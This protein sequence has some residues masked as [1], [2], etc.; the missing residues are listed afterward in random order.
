MSDPK[1]LSPGTLETTVTYLEMLQRPTRP[2]GA[3]PRADLTVQQAVL[4]TVS[5]Y[6]YLYDTVGERWLWVDRRKL[7]DVDL[8]RLIQ[9]DGVEV[10]V[11]YVS[12]VPAGYVELDRRDPA[13]IELVYFGLI[14]DFLGQRLGPFL[15]DWAIDRAWSSAPRRFWLHTC[16]LD[17]PKALAMYQSAGFVPYKTEV[18]LEADPRGPGVAGQA[19]AG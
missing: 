16:T 6:R 17:H 14:P 10:H 4:P 7:P 3:A 5:F 13:D 11:L 1:S 2:P 19:R 9:A 8:A 15:L 18:K 12:G